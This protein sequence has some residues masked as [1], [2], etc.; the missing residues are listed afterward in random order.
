V[1]GELEKFTD[2]PLMAGLTTFTPE[3]HTNTERPMLIIGI[4]DG[5]PAPLGY[6]DMR[7]G[8]YVQWW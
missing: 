3:L 8:D 4:T 1:R 5:K 6:Y 7:K 2:E